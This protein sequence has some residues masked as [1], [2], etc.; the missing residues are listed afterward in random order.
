VSAAGVTYDPGGHVVAG[1]LVF[2]SSAVG[3]VVVSRRVA[4]DPRWHGIATY[5]LVAGLAAIAAAIANGLFVIPDNAPLHG[6]AG[7]AQRA[8]ILL[9]VFPARIALSLRLLRVARDRR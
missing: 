4:R 5:I 9:V 7:L 3:L 8:L 1:A 6:W 2:I